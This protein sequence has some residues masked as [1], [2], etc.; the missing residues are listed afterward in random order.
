MKILVNGEQREF[1]NASLALPEL[2]IVAQVE[3]PEVVAQSEAD[4]KAFV[5]RGGEVFSEPLEMVEAW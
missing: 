1:E 3:S 5:I 2:L 4:V